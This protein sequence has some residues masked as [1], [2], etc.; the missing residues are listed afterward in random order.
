[1]LDNPDMFESTACFDPN[2]S[3]HHQQLFIDHQH[4]LPNFH[5]FPQIPNF[6]PAD[7]Q[8][9]INIEMDHQNPT[10]IDQINW[11]HNNSNLHDQILMGNNDNVNINNCLSN[12]IA[13]TPPDLLNLFQLPKCSSTLC[14]SDPTRID[15]NSGQVVYDPVLPVNVNV[16]V[17][18]PQ[19]PLFRELLNCGFN[20]SGCGSV[21][22][23]ME[24]EMERG[25]Q[26]NHHHLYE[27]DGVLEFGGGKGN[28]KDTKHF[29]TEKHRRQQ[30][31]GKYDA[32]KKLIPN[33]TKADRAS[34]VGDGIDY[35][36]ELKR[37]VEEL[38]ILVERKRCNRGRVK[39]HKTEDHSTLDVESIYTHGGG[40]GGG[41]GDAGH[42]QQAY[43]G[44]S[45]STMRSSW[46]QR[47]SKNIEI[48]V[49]IIDDEVTIKLVQQ[50]RI[51]CLLLVSKVL[52]DLQLD[53]HHVAGGL[54][55]D[56][57]SY[58]FNTKICE[59]SSVYASAIANKLIEVVDKQYATIPVTSSY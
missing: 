19:A 46:L 24:M 55:G 43:N 35:I 33:P 41:G 10:R 29:A 40:S 48:D 6:T 30:M 14:F 37:T 42:D 32:L 7:H 18:P 59:G 31:G 38:K 28:G 3:T 54:I 2:S 4:D 17:G 58:L 56:F 25:E 57:Y 53:L 50:K 9:L 15:Q 39:K 1:M 13:V 49:R 21:F 52:D 5:Q 8:H 26:S 23:E 34:I 51:N 44:N 47:K 36:N 27:G 22:G 20:L 12:Q 45:T 16:N 11:N